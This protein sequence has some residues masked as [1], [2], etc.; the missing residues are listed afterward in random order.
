MEDLTDDEI[1]LLLEEA[2]VAHVGLARDGDAYVIP[3]FVAFDGQQLW[4]HSRPG[5]KQDYLEA[6]DEACA[7]VTVVETEQVWASV[8]VFGPVEPVEIE[9]DRRRAMEALLERPMPP[10]TDDEEVE[11]LFFWRLTPTRIS[12]RKSVKPRE[13]DMF[14]IQ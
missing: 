6:T 2:Q 9:E 3:V 8:Q 10:S 5:L 1:S 7:T 4:F 12:G 13:P 11:E 14:D